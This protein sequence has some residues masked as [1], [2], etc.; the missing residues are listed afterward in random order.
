MYACC[1]TN[2][3]SCPQIDKILG[4]AAPAL[5]VSFLQ[6]IASEHDERLQVRPSGGAA[7]SAC[8]R[9]CGGHRLAMEG[10]ACLRVVPWWL[11]AGGG[12]SCGTGGR[13]RT[14]DRQPFAGRNDL[15][16]PA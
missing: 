5:F 3:V 7:S 10:G 9:A 13:R 11:G 8:G 12:S 15:C 14:P 4:K 6:Q 16:Y 2:P 1:I